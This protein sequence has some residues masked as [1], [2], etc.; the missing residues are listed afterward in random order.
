[1]INCL[2]V[3]TGEHSFLSYPRPNHT[4]NPACY[5][6]STLDPIYK[7]HIPPFLKFVVVVCNQFWQDMRP[8]LR[9]W[10]MLRGLFNPATVDDSCGPLGQS[11]V[12]IW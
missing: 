7:C 10:D 1:M 4:P 6:Y 9:L 5:Y 11:W 2:A 3:G 8:L 12:S